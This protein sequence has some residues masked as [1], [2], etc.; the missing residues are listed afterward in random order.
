MR[1]ALSRL[2]FPIHAL[3]PGERVGIWF[4]GCS[5]RCPGCISVDTW[6]TGTGLTTVDAVMDT[7]TPWLQDAEGVTVSGGEPFDQA[8]AL[9]ELL[10]RIRASS[11]C[12][13]LVYSGYSLKALAGRTAGFEGLIDALI[14]DPFEVDAPQTLALRGSDNQHLH[15]LTPLGEQRFRSYER[16]LTPSDRTLDVMFDEEGTV[17]MAGIPRRGDLQR[18][19]ARLVANGHMASTTEDKTVLKR[20]P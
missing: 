11:R 6:G 7:L 13:I 15:C 17:W 10:T 5:I 20:R 4:Q 16:P 3:G 19:M 2:H 1:I 12:D 18:L 14:T 9:R 8:E